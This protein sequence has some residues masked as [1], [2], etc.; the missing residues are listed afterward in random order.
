MVALAG[1]LADG[2][3]PATPTP[4]F[5]AQ[6]RQLL[7]PDKLL[8]IYG[9]SQIGQDAAEAAASVR[10]YLDAG[11]DHVTVGMAIG[12]DFAAGV[13]HLEQIAPALLKI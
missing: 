5:T 4:E 9:G 12:T 6:A 1:E 7:G 3:L 13:D 10:E 2:A 11:A 8:V